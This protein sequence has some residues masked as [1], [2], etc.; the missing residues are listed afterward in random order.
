M[1]IL[2]KNKKGLTHIYIVRDST[3]LSEKCSND[4]PFVASVEI[5]LCKQRKSLW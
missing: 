4:I 2:K 5:F 3:N 1:S